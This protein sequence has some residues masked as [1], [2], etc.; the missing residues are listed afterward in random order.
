MESLFKSPSKM[1]AKREPRLSLIAASVMLAC[2]GPALASTAGTIDFATN[3]VN[4]TGSNGQSRPLTRGT[5]FNTGDTIDTGAGRAQ[6]RFADG[7]LMSLPPQTTFKIE[8]YNYDTRDGS[9]NT[10]VGNLLR[11]G[12]RTITGLI[13][14]TN[15]DGYKLQTST[16]TIGIRGTEYSITTNPDGSMTMHVAQGSILVTNQGGSTQ[17][18]GGQ[19]VSLAGNSS[20][21]TPTNEKPY[22]APP[23]TSTPGV[24]GPSNPTQDSQSSAVPLLTG[25]LPATVAYIL[26]SGGGSI[27]PAASSTTATLSSNGV[28]TGYNVLGCPECTNSLGTSTAFAD[29]NDGVLAWGRWV[30]GITSNGTPLSGLGPKHYVVGL[31]VTAMPTS[32]TGTYNLYGG[33]PA[34]CSGASCS[35][36]IN[37][38]SSITVNF[39]SASGNLSSTLTNSADGRTFNLGGT[40]TL[41]PAGTFS[42]TNANP[43]TSGPGVLFAGSSSDG[44]LAGPGASHAGVAYSLNYTNSMYQTTTI[45][46]AAVYK[47]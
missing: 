34:S 11:G 15:R 23:G 45:S 27:Y 35:G 22:V 7:T 33:T 18:G 20:T 46:G 12:L 13:G 42:V 6:M 30:G 17:I 9:K 44:F 21:P 37:Y 40:F 41:S 4:V 29:G 28:L 36:S 31:P 2:G 1:L 38:S 3:G 24:S 14:K 5:S 47:K 16:A 26:G 25:T 19:S 39:G 32:G 43:L 10:L 8:N